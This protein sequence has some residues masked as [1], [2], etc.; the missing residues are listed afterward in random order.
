VGSPLMTSPWTSKPARWAARPVTPARSAG[1]GWPASV[2]CAA[3]VL[4]GSGAPHPS[5]V[6]KSFCT[7][8]TTCSVK[9]A[10]T[11]PPTLNC[12]RST[13]SSGPTWNG[14]SP[15]IAGR[16]GRRLKLRYRGTVKNNAWLTRRTAGLNLRNLL[17]RGLTRTPGVWVLAAQTA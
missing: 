1:P 16:G 9:P 3:T 5:P 12:G 17:G 15:E 2:H 13:G 10:V 4:C 8:E 11:G 6:V 14:S 7:N